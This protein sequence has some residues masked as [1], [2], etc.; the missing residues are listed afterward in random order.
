MSITY[1]V[2]DLFRRLSEDKWRRDNPF[3][4]EM[5]TV[6]KVLFH[7]YSEEANKK[8]A[9]IKW[10][11]RPPRDGQPGYQPCLFGRVAGANNALHVVLLDDD[12]L[13]DSDQHI[14]ERIQK[15]R[16]DWWQRSRSPRPGLSTPAHGFLLSIT[17]Q[18]VNFAAPDELLRQFSQEIL[19][20]WGCR[21]TKEPQGIVHWED[22]FLENPH[23]GRFVKFEFSVDFFAAA[24]D[25]RWWHDHRVPGGIAFTAN[26]VGHMRRYREW[27]EGKPDQKIWLLE[28]AM[29]TIAEAAKTAYG[30]ATWL[31]PLIDGHPIAADLL[32]PFSQTRKSLEGLDWTRYAG[33]LHTDHAVRPEFFRVDPEKPAEAKKNE[34]ILDFQYLFDPRSRDHI[35]FV[36]GVEVSKDEVDARVGRPEDYTYIASP[37]KPKP[38]REPG[39]GLADISG[40]AEVEAL[41]DV[42]R[43]WALTPEERSNLDG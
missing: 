6:S 14:S 25:R 33:H 39:V 20:L 7:P 21:S 18:R 5:E 19:S 16:Q 31:R 11:Q 38:K 30:E 24:G 40:R 23:T 28:T 22:I 26:S 15:G 13:R 4:P 43:G 36:E 27:Y 8:E 37:R 41:L 35:R 17:S 3:S 32:C 29:E 9:L 34:W 42:C 12:D 1:V 2:R 10:M